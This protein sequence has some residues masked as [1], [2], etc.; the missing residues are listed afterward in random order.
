VEPVCLRPLSYGPRV[1]SLTRFGRSVKLAGAARA[2]D[3]VKRHVEISA[4]P[5]V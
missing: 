5:R 4:D 1:V 3:V 2:A